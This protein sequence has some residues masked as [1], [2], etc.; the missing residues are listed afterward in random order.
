MS[1]SMDAPTMIPKPRPMRRL[2]FLR[3]LFFLS[4]RELQDKLHLSLV[5][6]ERLGDLFDGAAFVMQVHQISVSA[7]NRRRRQ[8]DDLFR[9]GKHGRRLFRLSLQRG[10]QNAAEL[11]PLV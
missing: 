8:F 4:A 10:G 2:R 7:A 11:V 3:M 9:F 6:A 1:W 5:H